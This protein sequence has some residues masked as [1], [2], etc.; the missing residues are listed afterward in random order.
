[1]NPD[2]VAGIVD[3]FGALSPAELDRALE[4]L[5]FRA[6][7][8]LPAD[9]VEQARDA[10]ALV[11]VEGNDG[12]LLVPGPTAFPT[13]PE[14]GEDLPHIL[15]AERRE[16]DRERAGE[17]ALERLRGEAARAV[18]DGD[19]ERVAELLDVTYDLETWAPVEASGVR[20]RLADALDAG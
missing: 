5:A 8:E 17:A 18:A 9:A 2:E 13:V 14:R 11:A 1:M 3:L 20:D 19:D 10:Y 7:G 16:V 15:D 4:E 12:E 6:D